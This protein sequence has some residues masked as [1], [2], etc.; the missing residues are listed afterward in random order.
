MDKATVGF[1]NLSFA[2]F[3]ADRLPDMKVVD[4]YSLMKYVRMVKTDAELRLLR[5][6]HLLNQTAI[7]KVVSSYVPGMTWHD[8][9][10]AYFLEV[11]RLGGF[12]VDRGSLVL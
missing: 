1:D 5:E 10:T 7:E 9:N 11:T 3:V 6:A 12:V 4:A 8:L 2:P